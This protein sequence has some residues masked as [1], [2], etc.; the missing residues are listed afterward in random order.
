MRQLT[1]SENIEKKKQ[2]KSR[3]DEREGA[4]NRDGDTK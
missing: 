3:K 2:M 4:V 1:M